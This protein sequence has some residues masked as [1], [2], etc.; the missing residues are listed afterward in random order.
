MEVQ[1]IINLLKPAGMTSHDGVY[2]LRKLT[3]IKKIGHT[4]TLDPMA[5]GVLPICIGNATKII[6][7]LDLD[8]KEYRC[9]M[10]LGIETDTY[11]I[12]GKVLNDQR[13]KVSCID[14]TAL[15][16]A[17]NTFIGEIYQLPPN[18]SSVRVQGKHLYEYARK[19]QEVSVKP[20]PVIIHNLKI[21][22]FDGNTGRVMFDI[23]CSKGTYIRSICHEA[24]KILKCGGAMSFLARISSGSFKIENSVTM[25]AL[26][27]EWSKHLLPM[28]FLSAIWANCLLGQRESDGS[29]TGL[30]EIK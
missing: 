22:R 3:G 9:E 5:A 30:F 25:E 23:A 27:E 19:G 1:G 13:Y 7:Y 24:G 14:E 4:G 6:D 17:F 2:F 10:I 16:S 28:D 11:D 12:W 18:Y 20:R 26:S 15:T 29:P 8:E 21:L